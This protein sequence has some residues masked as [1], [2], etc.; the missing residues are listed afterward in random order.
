[1]TPSLSPTRAAWQGSGCECRGRDIPSLKW[2]SPREAKAA[3]LWAL[4]RP[5][6]HALER[7]AGERSPAAGSRILSPWLCISPSLIQLPPFGL[8]HSQSH[9]RLPCHI[10]WWMLS[11]TVAGAGCGDVAGQGREGGGHHPNSRPS[12]AGEKKLMF[13]KR[14]VNISLSSASLRGTRC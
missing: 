12:G 2:L 5:H 4:A 10:S 6:I 9:T 13:S 3:L 14:V 1:M 8:W 7:W 11:Y